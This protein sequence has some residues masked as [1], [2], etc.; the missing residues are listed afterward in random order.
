MRRAAMNCYLLNSVQRLTDER[1][2]LICLKIRVQASLAPRDVATAPPVR[3]Q[4]NGPRQKPARSEPCPATASPLCP[5]N[6]APRAGED[7]TAVHGTVLFITEG[8]HARF[9]IGPAGTHLDPD[10]QKHLGI[11]ELFKLLPCLG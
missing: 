4:R 9:I 7:G 6:A 1:W 10:L 2:R 8:A 11:H 5:R 3:E